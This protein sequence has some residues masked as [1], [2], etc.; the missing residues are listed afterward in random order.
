M[1][2]LLSLAF[3]LCRTGRPITLDDGPLETLLADHLQDPL[4]RELAGVE[5]HVDEVFG[6]LDLD[7][8]EARKP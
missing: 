3:S 8:R 1:A 7:Q 4:R 5:C 2:A 6:K